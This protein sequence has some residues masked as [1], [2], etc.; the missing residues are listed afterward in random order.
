[1]RLS[2]PTLAWYYAASVLIQAWA[3]T[4]AATLI[5][6]PTPKR[7]DQN[8]LPTAKPHTQN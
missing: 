8:V 3:Y 4:C 2:D 6:Q 1:M 5:I 7:G